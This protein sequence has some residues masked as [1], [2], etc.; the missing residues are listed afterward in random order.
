M[1]PWLS[2]LFL[3]PEFVIPGM[4]LLS[5]PVIIHLINRLRYRRV[6]WAAMEFLLAS[7]QRNKRRGLL[8]Q[9]LL[10]LLRM[11][12]VAALV[13]LVA[14]PL[15]DP[16]HFSFVPGKKAQH[17]VLIDDSGSVRDRSGEATAFDMART[18]LSKLAAEGERKPDTQLLTVLLASHAAQPILTQQPINREFAS[19]LDTL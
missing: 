1:P 13:M 3:H 16:E 11:L 5:L 12:V 7:Q 17:V 15:L 6:K 9:L 2:S 19:R 18:V 8:E 4:A 14:R 10:L